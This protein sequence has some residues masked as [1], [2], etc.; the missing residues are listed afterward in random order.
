MHRVVV[1]G[2]QLA[3][4]HQ[5]LGHLVRILPVADLGLAKTAA[6]TGP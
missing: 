4:R 6:R 2:E 1:F 3:R 5:D